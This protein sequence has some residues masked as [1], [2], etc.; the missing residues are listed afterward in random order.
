MIHY[1]GFCSS[2]YLYLKTATDDYSYTNTINKSIARDNIQD[3]GCH[4]YP[5][6]LMKFNIL[7]FKI[8]PYFTSQ[9]FIVRQFR[10]I[11][12]PLLLVGKF[13]KQADNS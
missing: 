4:N 9:M 6:Y 10:K 7:N 11:L 1:N 2:E 3:I 5:L 13:S 12:L 8:C